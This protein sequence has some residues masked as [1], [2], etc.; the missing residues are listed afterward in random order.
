MPE[1]E[2]QNKIRLDEARRKAVEKRL[3]R[4]DGIRA[5]MSDDKKLSR[6]NDLYGKDVRTKE[7]GRYN[8]K[9]G[10]ASQALAIA[11]GAKDI[12][13]APTEIQAMDVPIYG[14]AFALALL[15]DLLD[16]TVVLALPAIGTVITICVSIAIG[17]ILLFDGISVSQRRM[18][19]R[20]TRR[21]LVLIAGT[22][23]EGILFGLNFFPIETLV[24][25]IIYWMSLTDRKRSAKF[26][27]GYGEVYN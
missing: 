22:L 24:V 10:K 15:K 18:A 5:N 19:R 1:E 12:I 11:K 7:S 20:M 26:N 4:A 3:D 9:L 27:N 8:G 16:L 21:F 23:A 14:L 17:L 6:R 13:T 25:A 2:T